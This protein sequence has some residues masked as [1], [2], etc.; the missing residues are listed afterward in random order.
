HILTACDDKIA[1]IWD[2]HSGAI[3]KKFV[4][5]AAVRFARFSPDGAYVATAEIS[6]SLRVWDANS[7]KL[8][9]T[10]PQQ[11]MQVN[12]LQF[13][14]NGERLVMAFQD[15]TAQLY[16]GRTCKPVGPPLL[17]DAAVRDACFSPEGRLLLTTSRDGTVRFWDAMTGTRVGQI[18]RHE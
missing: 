17:H 11:A 6:G 2:A 15:A 16:A 14:Q 3:T 13:S 12:A 9:Q 4:H 7:G 5:E 8:V 1:R 10:G 18:L